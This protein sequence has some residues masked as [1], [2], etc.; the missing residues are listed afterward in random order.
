MCAN[1]WFKCG[2]YDGIDYGA[3]EGIRRGAYECID[4]DAYKGINCGTY[5]RIDCDE[6]Y[7][8]YAYEGT[9]CEAVSGW[10]GDGRGGPG[11]RD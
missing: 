9:V 11:G 1:E 8:C 7:D 2:A 5:E 6:W 3:Y 4:F 10:Q